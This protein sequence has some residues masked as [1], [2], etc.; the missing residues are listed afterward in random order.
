MHLRDAQV[1]EHRFDLA[2]M[3][4]H[5]R[6]ARIGNRTPR[7]DRRRIAIQRNQAALRPQ[8]VENFAAVPATAES[9]IHINAIGHN[10]QRG[11]RFVEQY[12]DMGG[13]GAHSARFSSPAGSNL[14]PSA[15]IASCCARQPASDHTSKWLP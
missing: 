1:V 5:Q 6:K 14:S 9:C 4:M 12:G 3:R 11:D 13:V 15:K 10:R 2:E 8:C 7:R